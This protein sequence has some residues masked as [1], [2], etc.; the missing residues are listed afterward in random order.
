MKQNVMAEPEVT[1]SKRT[2]LD[3]FLVIASNGLWDALSN[4]VA[5]QVVRRCLNG[6]IK[7]R[8]PK[9]L[10][11]SNAAEVA[12][13]LAELAVARGSQVPSR[14]L[15]MATLPLPAH[16][17]HLQALLNPTNL[18]LLIITLTLPHEPID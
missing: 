16:T 13:V 7:R 11:G 8:F 1:V 17:R 14:L 9:E 5:H 12:A 2:K 6:H 3:D 18:P 15:L 4:E 10:R